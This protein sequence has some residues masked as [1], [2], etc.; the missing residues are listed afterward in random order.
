YYTGLTFALDLPNV[1][2]AP[3]V[4]AEMV[5]TAEL[6]AATLGGQLVDDN[7]KPLTEHGIV[8]IRR[9]LE[10]IFH[11]MESQGLPAGGMLARRL[12]S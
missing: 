7:R 3:A 2:D 5:S 8:S 1:P 9:S 12:F 6:F 10:K 4:L 11:D